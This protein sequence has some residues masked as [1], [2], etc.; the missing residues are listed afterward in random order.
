MTKLPKK[1]YKLYSMSK[2][3]EYNSVL[4][5]S[6]DFLRKGTDTS[7]LYNT[8][9]KSLVTKIRALDEDTARVLPTLPKTAKSHI[10]REVNTEAGVV[11]RGRYSRTIRNLWSDVYRLGKKHSVTDL[12][13]DTGL[14]DKQLK[15]GVTFSS[16]QGF[17]LTDLIPTDD[18]A[19]FADEELTPAQ[20]RAIARAK[21]NL[22]ILRNNVN[23]LKNSG[24][25][26]NDFVLDNRG[27]EAGRFTIEQRI[28]FLEMSQEIDDLLMRAEASEKAF[29]S[30]QYLQRRYR[31]LTDDYA[32]SYDTYIKE[33]IASYLD[34]NIE[35]VKQIRDTEGISTQLLNTISSQLRST[36]I[37]LKDPVLKA[38]TIL[39]TELNLAYNFGK[40]LGYT[41]P[42]DKV[43]RF[44]WNADWELE[45]LKA[46]YLVC[47]A[48][49][50]MDGRIYTVE[51]LLIVGT[52]LDRG[53]L[54]YQ[55]QTRTS[56]KN[57]T[58]PSI[59]FHPNCQCYWTLVREDE[60]DN[61]EE[62]TTYIDTT[63]PP[64]TPSPLPGSSEDVSRVSSDTATITAATGLLVGGAFLLA[65]SN[66]W[67]LFYK[68]ATEATEQ[69]IK[70][71]VAK[72]VEE[73]VTDTFIKVTKYIRQEVSPETVE[74]YEELLEN[75]I[76]TIPE[77]LPSIEVEIIDDV[78]TT[79]S[80]TKPAYPEPS[81]P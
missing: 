21:R 68:T 43:R 26:Y 65:R 46:N 76:K 49:A 63:V 13:F 25:L 73:V 54:K 37:E 62:A 27:S 6:V 80:P 16:L 24:V 79:P 5:K 55:G 4:K 42:T 45:N 74:R 56:F 41:S 78:I 7:S 52:R 72:P 17:S 70:Q 8:V 38:D 40:L 44:R 66:A 1:A 58:M 69:V 67:R 50:Q 51:D 29:L 10:L 20:M 3:K 12:M 11:L 39:R 48:C 53:I 19:E 71:Q 28:K 59:P 34:R 47:T 30:D 23:A 75:T 2:S 77:K 22:T 15:S 64:P 9:A 60:V 81:I 36:D 31:V 33:Q 35:G 61:I 57:P 18:I 14:F 32:N